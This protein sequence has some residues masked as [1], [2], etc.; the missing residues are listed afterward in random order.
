MI[1]KEGW[2]GER[3]KRPTR[4]DGGC[5]KGDQPYCDPSTITLTSLVDG[6]GRTIDEIRATFPFPGLRS[7]RITLCLTS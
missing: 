5:L 4:H 6:A 3:K 1:L 2:L 7:Q